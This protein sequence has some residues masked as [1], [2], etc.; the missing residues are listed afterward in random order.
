MRSDLLHELQ[1]TARKALKD[2]IC[3]CSGRLKFSSFDVDRVQAEELE[4][5]PQYVASR[6]VELVVASNSLREI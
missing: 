3:H 1:Y 6:I 4:E 2:V 5:S